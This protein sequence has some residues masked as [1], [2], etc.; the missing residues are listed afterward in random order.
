MNIYIHTFG[1]EALDMS[2]TSWISLHHPRVW[3]DVWFVRIDTRMSMQRCHWGC[4]VPCAADPQVDAKTPSI[5]SCRT[6][7]PN[8][9]FLLYRVT[10]TPQIA[11]FFK[12][13]YRKISRFCS[14]LQEANLNDNFYV[15]VIIIFIQSVTNYL[16]HPEYVHD[17]HLPTDGKL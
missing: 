10:S 2:Q 16:I 9:F 12:L 1:S 13:F 17:V 8:L 4:Q 7:Q 5:F 3:S 15:R 14:N 6:A 11:M